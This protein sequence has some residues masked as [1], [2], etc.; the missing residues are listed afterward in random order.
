M[1]Q[2][3][4]AFFLIILSVACIPLQSH[5]ASRLV[6][7]IRFVNHAQ[8]T[9]DTSFI[10]THTKART[11]EELGRNTIAHDVRA[12]LDT[13][14]FS[15]V[16]VSIIPQD[17]GVVLVY[18]FINRWTLVAPLEIKGHDRLRA[19]R[20]RNLVDLSPGDLVDD[21]VLGAHTRA[22]IDEYARYHY[23]HAKVSWTIHPVSKDLSQARVTL[24]V[25]E[26]GKEKVRKFNIRGN[27]AIKRR[28]LLDTVR[29][30]N[31]W[32]PFRFFKSLDYEADDLT[33]YRVAMQDAYRDRGYL[34]THIAPLQLTRT[35]GKKPVIR[36]DIQEG[37]PYL[38]GKVT[39]SG[40]KLF[41]QPD[42]ERAAARVI[43]PGN[44]ASLRAIGRAAAAVR[45]YYEAKGYLRTRVSYTLTPYEDTHTADI[46]FTVKEGVLTHLRHVLIQGNDR[47]RDK[48]LRRELLAYPGE[49]YDGVKV[50][51]SENRLRNLGF[52]SRVDALPLDTA[53][54]DQK[55]LLIDVEE[56]PTGQFMV[57]AGFSSIDKVIGFLEVS[58]GNFDL[59]NWPRFTGGGQKLRLRAELGSNRTEYDLS[60]V[61]PW[62]LDRKLALGF[63]LYRSEVDYDEYDLIRTGFSPSLAKALPGRN[64][65]ELRYRIENREI[66]DVSDTDAYVVVD[67]GEPYSFNRDE[68]TTQSSFR[69][70]LSHDTRNRSFVPTSGTRA[71][72]FYELAGGVFGGDA[73]LYRIGTKWNQYFSPW[74]SH[75]ISLRLRYEVVEEYGDSYDLSISDRLFL[76]GGRS[77]RGF[78]YREVGPKAVPVDST[79]GYDYRPIGGKS[80]AFA[81]AE[82]TIPIVK[83]IRLA[84]FVD[85]GNVWTDAYE[86]QPDD[87]ATTAGIGL[88]FD[89][90]GFPIR[91][92][93]AWVVDPD[94]ELT[95][96]DPWVFWIGY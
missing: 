17:D 28:D 66:T 36:V 82:Y 65:M 21:Q 59:K 94:D 40:I 1:K 32:N 87:I 90:P 47:T 53:W 16:K 35:P 13:G 6:R 79:S 22:L 5:A 80:L 77:L 61:E 70:T 43:R 75:V 73:E 50:R 72:I 88:R 71:S 7:E 11:D 10:K 58:Q 29:Y 52:F 27:Q 60:F 92:D 24:T 25:D 85:T 38:V 69:L 15:D 54:D 23:N 81:S 2:Y 41:P 63:D 56:K 64:R 4:L 19:R 86:I 49:I 51:R 78:E 33:T 31:W 42:V 20:I 62:F 67:T 57:G 91:I 93:R 8:G 18:G 83:G 26:G 89:L 95:D 55:D 46:H 48:V 68:D 74:L 12:L 44:A 37:E 30:P 3:T 9:L 96:E 84:G 45:D 39:I 76:G 34:D 14:L